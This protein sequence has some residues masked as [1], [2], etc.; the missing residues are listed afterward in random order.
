MLAQPYWYGFFMVIATKKH[1]TRLSY[2]KEVPI[3]H[4]ELYSSSGVKGS[5]IET[6]GVGRSSVTLDPTGIA[7]DCTVALVHHLPVFVF[8]R[9]YDNKVYCWVCRTTNLG[10]GGRLFGGMSTSMLELEIKFIHQSEGYIHLHDWHWPIRGL[11]SSAWLK[12][13]N[14]RATSIINQS[15]SHKVLVSIVCPHF[16]G[17]L[18]TNGLHYKRPNKRA[19]LDKRRRMLSSLRRSWDWD[20]ARFSTIK[21]ALHSKKPTD[22]KVS[23]HWQISY[24]SLPKAFDVSQT[25]PHS[26]LYCAIT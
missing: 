19:V 17:V 9:F 23:H 26:L 20:L 13:T 25:K 21:L 16:R 8:H 18:T 14:Q 24:V 10:E 5:R 3:T 4:R 2:T 7:W 22:G 6:C 1:V 15:Q 11:H 12:L